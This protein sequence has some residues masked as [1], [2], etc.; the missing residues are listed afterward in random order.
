MTTHTDI[1]R[2]P[3]WKKL[4]EHHRAVAALH[5]RELF[6][7]DPHR[8]KDL[9]V[10]AGDLY[11]DYSKHR[12]TRETLGLL[13]DLAR[14]GG[15]EEQRDAMFAGAHINVSEDRPVLHMALRERRD[16]TLLVDGQDVIGDVHAV[17]DRMGAFTDRIRSGD[18]RGATGQ[19]IQTVVNIGIGGSPGAVRIERRSR[20]S[21]VHSFGP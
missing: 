1:T 19:P 14:A 2:T 6:D 16:A 13:L 17:L 12:I 4:T 8:G 3:L 9:T 20:R 11:V 15:V 21:A 5:P 18:W 10:T 7:T